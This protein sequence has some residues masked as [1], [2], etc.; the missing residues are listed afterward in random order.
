MI[1]DN[2]ISSQYAGNQYP[3]IF[4]AFCFEG[5]VL[6]DSLSTTISNVQRHNMHI[7]QMTT[8]FDVE[9]AK[10]WLFC[11]SV[12][13]FMYWGYGTPELQSF[14]MPGQMTINSIIQQPSSLVK[15]VQ[16]RI[17]QYRE[18]NKGCNNMITFG[19]F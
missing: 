13:H 12:N 6:A 14:Q 11:Q 16:Q 9:S 5:C 8:F 1:T 18:V 19:G 7:I 3:N 17:D 4:A 2:K 10:R 15:A